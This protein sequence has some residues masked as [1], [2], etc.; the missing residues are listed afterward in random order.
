MWE[1][2][3]ST[4]TACS[5]LTIAKID[6]RMLL[7]TLQPELHWFQWRSTTHSWHTIAWTKKLNSKRDACA[8]SHPGFTRISGSPRTVYGHY[9]IKLMVG[10]FHLKL[11]DEN[12]SLWSLLLEKNKQNGLMSSTKQAQIVYETHYLKITLSIIMIKYLTQK[13]G[14]VTEVVSSSPNVH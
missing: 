7:H 3:G 13:A 1:R 12:R 14:Y 4:G 8:G 11:Y 5:S 10:I 6:G 9:H 2:V